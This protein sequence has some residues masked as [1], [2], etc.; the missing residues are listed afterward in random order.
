[1]RAAELGSERA[2][3]AARAREIDQEREQLK[4]K[5]GSS[6]LENGV[7]EFADETLLGTG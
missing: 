7:E 1:M 6:F 5:C 2:L 3:I 4:R